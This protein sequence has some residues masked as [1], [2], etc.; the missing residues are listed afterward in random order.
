MMR[1]RRWGGIIAWLAAL[2]VLGSTV[3]GTSG[4]AHAAPS[5]S[6][7]ALPP[8]APPFT[9]AR[10]A[11][12][13]LTSLLFPYEGDEPPV[14]DGV[15]LLPVPLPWPPGSGQNRSWDIEVPGASPVFVLAA[16]SPAKTGFAPGAAILVDG[17][18]IPSPERY[19]VSGIQL[20]E[21]AGLQD[22]A[23][24]GFVLGG[25]EPGRHA[26]SVSCNG[27]A[28]HDGP[29][30][31]TVNA[32]PRTYVLSV[33]PPPVPAQ[34]AQNG[35]PTKTTPDS[36]PVAVNEVHF[37]SVEDHIFWSD[38]L[39]TEMTYRVYLPP[40]YADGA[41][42]TSAGIAKRYPVLYL[43]HGLG[44]GYQQWTNLGFPAEL[45]K[46]LAL[47]GDA[48]FMVVMPTGRSGYW[49][50]HADGG[51]RFGDYVAHDLVAHMDATYRTIPRR[52]ARAV[53]GVSMGGHG[54]L[55]LALN[56]PEVF[57]TAGAH[58][59]ALRRRTEAPPFLGG[60]FSGTQSSPGEQAFL[61]RD[62]ISLVNHSALAKPPRLW[63]DIGSSDEWSSLA[64]QLHN[65]LLEHTWEHSWRPGIGGHNGSYWSRRVPEYVRF[66]R[67]AFSAAR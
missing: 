44:A 54:A 17:V 37:G 11:R 53:G 67:S 34:T 35:V 2:F 4:P 59:P 19:A 32:G 48:P 33:L 23:A 8:D 36:Q 21:S 31:S 7:T 15:F 45:D 64:E 16:I 49:V 22:Y 5:G 24:L 66:Y 29:W 27:C 38:A 62:P 42:N 3:G 1:P 43:L 10:R 57:G 30:L 14:E 40:G 12:L 61:A 65:T 18:P 39:G 51:P 28:G 50:N 55:Q 56:Y 20:P 41:T 52:E 25:F 60:Y 63:I 13:A 26:I 47:T 9:A 46:Q 58:S 6:G